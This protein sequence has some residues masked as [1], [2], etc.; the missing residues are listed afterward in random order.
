MR[1]FSYE[2]Q[3][4]HILSHMSSVWIYVISRSHPAPWPLYSRPSVRLVCQITFPLNTARKIFQPSSFEPAMFIRTIALFHVLP[5]SVALI[6]AKGHAVSG[7][8]NLR[9]L[10][11][12]SNWLG[13]ERLKLN[14]QIL[15]QSKIYVIKGNNWLLIAPN[16]NR[17]RKQNKYQQGKTNKQTKNQT[18]Q[19]NK[20][21]NSQP[22][23]PQKKKKIVGMRLDVSAPIFSPN[24]VWW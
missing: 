4:V 13:G 15:P 20:Q 12:F 10:A 16:R 2:F 22:P 9:F 14:I 5:L 17:T 18:K 11:H 23:P 6:L 24:L 21:T 7:K 19:T 3:D 8:Q 1:G